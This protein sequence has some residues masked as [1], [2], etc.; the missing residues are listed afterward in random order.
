MHRCELHEPGRPNIE[1]LATQLVRILATAP[2]HA[3]TIVAAKERICGATLPISDFHGAL[4]LSESRRWIS[5]S[6]DYLSVMLAATQLR[7]GFS[8]VA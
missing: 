6:G 5:Y 4:A 7:D 8:M 1:Q 3:L 2:G